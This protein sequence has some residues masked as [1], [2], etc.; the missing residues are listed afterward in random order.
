MLVISAV[1]GHLSANVVMGVVVGGALALSAW[2]LWIPVRLE[3]SSKG[4]T[5]TV[6]GRRRRIPWTEFAKYEVRRHGVLL[7][8]ES[9]DSP[10]AAFRSLYVRW[11]HHQK[12]LLEILDFFVKTRLDT[13]SVTTRTYRPQERSDER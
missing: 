3:L 6:L 8:T 12:D 5:Q 4:V 1:A 11:N 9:G 2:R 13:Q 7:F 10:L